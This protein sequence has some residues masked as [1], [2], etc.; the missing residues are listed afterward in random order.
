MRAVIVCLI[1]S[2]AVAAQDKPN[3]QPPKED[4]TRVDEFYRITSQIQD[5]LWPGWS[6]IPAPLMLVTADTEFLTHHPAPPAEMKKIADDWYARPRQFSTNLQATFPAFG[7]PSV[8]VIGEPSNTESKTSTPWVFTVVHE[9][10]HQLQNAQPGYFDAVKALDLGKG[11]T[12][13]MWMLNYPFPYDKRAVAEGFAELRDLLVRTL[14]EKDETRFAALA[15][16]YVA[17]R[18]K[19]FG[20]LSPDDRKYS[21]SSFG[22]KGSHDTRKSSQR[23]HVPTISRRHNSPLCQTTSHFLAMQLV[24]E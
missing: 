6:K 15:K 5:G 1:L 23:R 21:T 7:P 13:G 19:F 3:P 9:H 2:G 24:P 12:T 20:S 17:E 22:R 4:A 14:E 10:F 8:I 11:D 18:H 16:E